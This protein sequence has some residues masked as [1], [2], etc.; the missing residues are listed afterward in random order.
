MV[1][2]DNYNANINAITIREYIEKTAYLGANT[3]HDHRHFSVPWVESNYTRI[4]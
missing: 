1:I 4:C 2:F 3:W